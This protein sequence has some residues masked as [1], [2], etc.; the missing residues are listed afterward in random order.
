MATYM[1]SVQS[2]SVIT[3]KSESNAMPRLRQWVGS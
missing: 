3:L 2:S 1:M